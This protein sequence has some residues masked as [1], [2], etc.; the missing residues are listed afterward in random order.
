[1]NLFK[2]ATGIVLCLIIVLSA[3]AVP[4]AASAKSIPTTRAF[5]LFQK[6]VSIVL[7]QT[8]NLKAQIVR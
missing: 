3:I 1:M 6:T 4:T 5:T 7:I 8:L 2:K